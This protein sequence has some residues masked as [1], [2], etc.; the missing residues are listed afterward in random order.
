MKSVIEALFIGLLFGLGL[1]LSGMTQ[2]DKVLN[3]LDVAGHWD[4]SLALVMGGALAVTFPGFFWL[5]RRGVT[6]RGE[7]LHLPTRKDISL[8]LV[9]GASL[10]GIG[11]GLVGYCPGPALTALGFAS[12]E[13]L[14]L[15]LSLFVGFALARWLPV[16]DKQ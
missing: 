7:D 5:R 3:F 1:A 10:F 2:P 8:P 14:W 4:P 13:A 6:L 12:T 9:I 11:W 15:S 16:P